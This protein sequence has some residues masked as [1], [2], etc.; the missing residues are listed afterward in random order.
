MFISTCKLVDDPDTSDLIIIAE[1]N[2]DF[3]EPPSSSNEDDTEE[4]SDCEGKENDDVDDDVDDEEDDVEDDVDEGDDNSSCPFSSSSNNDDTEVIPECGGK[5]NDEVDEEEMS[6]KED[7]KTGNELMLNHHYARSIRAE[8]SADPSEASSSISY[9]DDAIP[10][11]A[12]SF[13]E[14]NPT[15]KPGDLPPERN[16]AWKYSRNNEID[17]AITKEGNN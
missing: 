2:D 12:F 9:S 13:I 11:N 7:V 3:S 5:E 17:N 4:K 16:N 15:V 1:Q 14:E 6:E 10:V 8:A